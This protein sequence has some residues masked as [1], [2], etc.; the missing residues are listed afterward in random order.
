MEIEMGRWYVYTG[1]MTRLGHDL[2]IPTAS[3]GRGTTIPISIGVG[4]NFHIWKSTRV[5]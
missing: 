2:T 5:N 1:D 3:K 4:K